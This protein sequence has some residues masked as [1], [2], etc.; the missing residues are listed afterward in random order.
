M[1]PGHRQL[2][3]LCLKAVD[4]VVMAGSF[5][6][7]AGTLVPGSDWRSLQRL[8]EV[9]LKISNLVLFAGLMATWY[10]IFAAFGLYRS[11]RLSSARA[12]AL[13][14]VKATSL[15]SAAILGVASLISIDLVTPRFIAVFWVLSAALTTFARLTLRFVLGRFRVRDETSAIS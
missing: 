8:F 5:D 12:E 7:A 4:L 1:N 14:V 6:L 11:R 15:G 10:L 13:D 9:R 3:V 2:L